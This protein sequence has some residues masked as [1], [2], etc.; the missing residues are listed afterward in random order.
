MCPPRPYIQP[1]LDLEK[2]PSSLA[3]G[4]PLPMTLRPLFQEMQPLGVLPAGREMLH[5]SGHRE[6]LVHVGKH[7][8]IQIWGTE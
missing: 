5:N 7:L 8:S 1:L 4:L 3:W 6:G 2:S